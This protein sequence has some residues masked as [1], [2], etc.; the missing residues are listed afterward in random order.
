VTDIIFDGN[1][2]RSD[3]TKPFICNTQ[4]PE[5]NGEK[6]RRIKAVPIFYSLISRRRRRVE[7]AAEAAGVL[8]L[9]KI[10]KFV[11]LYWSSG[12]H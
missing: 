1:V 11:P 3:K 6:L 4:I 10:S 8:F 5:P 9:K 2:F 7:R 12:K